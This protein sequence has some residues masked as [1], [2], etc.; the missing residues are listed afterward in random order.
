MHINVYMWIHMHTCM[1]IYRHTHR[2]IAHT[3]ITHT[4]IHISNLLSI[5]HKILLW[6]KRHGF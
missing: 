6:R 5:Q 3:H 2:Y 1:Y 4:Y